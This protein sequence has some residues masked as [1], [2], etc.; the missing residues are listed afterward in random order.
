VV[1]EA[2]EEE[3]AKEE[4]PANS[5]ANKL[6]ESKGTGEWKDLAAQRRAEVK[7]QKAVQDALPELSPEEK[8]ELARRQERRQESVAALGA[9]MDQLFVAP[10]PAEDK[11]SSGKKKKKQQTIRLFG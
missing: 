1:E 7:K 5:F 9:K 2:E 4:S 10:S 3:T 11:P 6:K 8:E